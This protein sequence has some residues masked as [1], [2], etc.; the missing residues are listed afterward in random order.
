MANNTDIRLTLEAW[1]KITV[2][3]W[4]HKIDQLQIRNTSQL[5]NSF[6]HHVITSAGGDVAR[7]EFAFNFYGKFI[8]MG[9]GRGTDI[10]DVGN[11]NRK[12]KKW[13]SKTMYAELKKLNEILSLKYTRKGALAIIETIEEEK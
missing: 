1:A 10:S 3:N 8:D 5:F 7:I 12:P 4:L 11:T 9:V 13:Y 6:V 2:N